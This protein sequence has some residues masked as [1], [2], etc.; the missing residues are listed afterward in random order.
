[1]FVDGCY[2]NPYNRKETKMGL[3]QRCKLTI[4][5]C[6]GDCRFT[7]DSLIHLIMLYEK[8]TETELLYLD[9]SIVVTDDRA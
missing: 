9:I 2:I 4:Q 5:W 6:S 1:M 8:P 7:R 3:E